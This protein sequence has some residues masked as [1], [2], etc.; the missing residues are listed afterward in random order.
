MRANGVVD[1]T[2]RVSVRQLAAV[3]KVGQLAATVGDREERAQAVI[4]EI[5]ELVNC[6]AI[7][8]SS[9]NPLK[10][11]HEHVAQAGY[12]DHVISYTN[13][14]RFLDDAT[15]RGVRAT[16]RPRRMIDVPGIEKTDPFVSVFAPAGY[17]EGVITCL[18]TNDGRYTGMLYLSTRRDI[19]A[20]EDAI[21]L[22]DLASSAL[23]ELTDITHSL[24]TIA[25][26][27]LPS[28]AAVVVV[29]D[30][31]IAPL[32][33]RSGGRLLD[34]GSGIVAE[35]VR[36]APHERGAA[37]FLWYEAGELQ[38][39]HAARVGSTPH[40]VVGA[41]PT[42][43]VLTIR[44]LEVL[45]ALATGATNPEIADRLVVSRHT[46]SRHI[47]HILEKLGVRTR[48]AAASRAVRDGLILGSR[49]AKDRSSE[50]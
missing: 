14:A 36:R 48:A 8:L 29:A 50:G 13:D 26:A 5:A 10:V 12:P 42:T 24:R 27:L 1:E 22:L 39:V 34:D 19:P 20:S 33:G 16:H 43:C 3:T 9:W 30:G 46:V 25:E 28:S 49:V 2:V 38:R 7:G 37:S 17:S 11:G 18:H 44:E 31:A 41:A 47:E 45:T 40:I 15:Y 6:D 21:T 32:P 4:E 23:A 35:A